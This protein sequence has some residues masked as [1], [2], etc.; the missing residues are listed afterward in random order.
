MKKVFVGVGYLTG[1][2]LNNEGDGGIIQLAKV[3]ALFDNLNNGDYIGIWKSP[4]G[5]LYI[6]QSTI[7][8]YNEGDL[9]ILRLGFPREEAFYVAK[10]KST[11]PLRGDILSI[12]AWELLQ[13]KLNEGATYQFKDK[14]LYKLETIE[15]ELL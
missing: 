15:G 8:S 3:K 1:N 4:K 10:I 2:I 11:I 13:L 6:E 7:L 5:H 14:V 12:F 9:D